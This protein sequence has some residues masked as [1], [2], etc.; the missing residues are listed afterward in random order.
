MYRL[1]VILS[2]A[3]IGL[4]AP[5]AAQGH[6]GKQ[7]RSYVDA[8]G[9]QC[10]E[11]THLKGNGDESYQVKCKGPRGERGWKHEDR[12]DDERY[13]NDRGAR[14]HDD[15]DRYDD[16]HDG[17]GRYDNGRY[18][19]GGY[20][21]G[22]YGNGGTNCFDTRGRRCGVVQG[23]SYPTTLPEMAAAVIWGRG[24]RT[25]SATRWLGGND[26][27][28]RYVDRDGD[29]RPEAASWFGSDGRMI[30]QWIDTNRDGRADAVRIYRDGRLV[31]LVGR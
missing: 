24:Q 30:Q 18:D 17:D 14:G 25:S 10:R 31:R 11:T 22:R 9:R 13:D 5:L 6:S 26:Y 12:D 27:R 23:S 7:T 3:T 29:G 1:T 16:D 21:N 28:V 4:A 19:N 15:D 8:R 2:C 20:G